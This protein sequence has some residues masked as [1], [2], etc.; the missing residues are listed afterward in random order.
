[1]GSQASRGAH[2]VICELVQQHAAQQP[3]GAAAATLRAQ[4]PEAWKHFVAPLLALPE[5]V[6]AAAAAAAAGVPPE[7]QGREG[8]EVAVVD[9]A[10]M[11]GTA[12]LKALRCLRALLLADTARRGTEQGAGAAADGRVLA[13]E[14]ASALLRALCAL[15]VSAL[16]CNIRREGG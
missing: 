6:A 11:D 16:P 15:V 13:A 8:G 3:A 14:E 7:P 4:L 9:G 10:A 1:M 5:I 2:R 12:V